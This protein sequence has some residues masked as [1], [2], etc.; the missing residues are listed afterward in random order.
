MT[1]EQ[2][3][4]HWPREAELDEQS[5]FVSEANDHAWR[6]TVAPETWP[7]HKLVLV[8][9]EGAGKTHLARL[10]ADRTGALILDAPALTGDEALPDDA[11]AVV[12]EDADR[13]PAQAEEFVFHLHNS[14]HR[15][16]RPF[17]STACTPPTSWPT[18]LPDLVSRMTAASVVR[19]GNPDDDLLEAV[20]LKLLVDRHLKF[21]DALIPYLVTHMNRSFADASRMV[22][23]LERRAVD[24]RRAISR[25]LA[26]EILDSEAETS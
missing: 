7:A 14:L 12:L 8:G 4:F 1:G 5:Y 16:G 23:M 9:P 24:E 13:L 6:V 15:T 11:P 18:A 2:L 17:L 25:R 22:A 21:E 19:I 10:F 3:S 26:R 20:L